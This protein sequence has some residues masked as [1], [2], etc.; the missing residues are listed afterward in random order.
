M[1]YGTVQQR[2][3][4]P[5]EANG[6]RI[7]AS[8]SSPR[9]LVQNENTGVVTGHKPDTLVAAGQAEKDFG[10]GDKVLWNTAQG[11]TTGTVQRRLTH[12]TQIKDFKV[13]ASPEDP[14]YLVESEKTGAEAAH[15][16]EALD[17]VSKS[18]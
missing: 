17:S 16:P 1:S 8:K 3:T 11:E 18:S 12:D 2:V 10:P 5:T 9:Y 4:Q 7:D 14:K 6:Q 15:Q 13:K